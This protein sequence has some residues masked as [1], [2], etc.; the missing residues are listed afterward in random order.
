MRV[1]QYTSIL[2]CLIAMTLMKLYQIFKCASILVPVSQITLR[3]QQ[4]IAEVFTFSPS[5]GIFTSIKNLKMELQSHKRILSFSIFP[6]YC[7]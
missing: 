7:F 1:K 4:K 6:E 2:K 3:K 5:T